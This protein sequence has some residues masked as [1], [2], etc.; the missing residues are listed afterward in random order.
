MIQNFRNILSL[1]KSSK[2]LN[3]ATLFLI[4]A[5]VPL[6][7]FIAQQQQE[8]RQRASGPITAP[9]PSPTFIFGKSVLFNNISTQNIQK[10]TI[11]RNQNNTLKLNF[12]FT[13]EFWVKFKE[14]PATEQ[15]L[16][17]V[18][19]RL[20]VI[21]RKD[22]YGYTTRVV[23]TSDGTRSDVFDSNPVLQANKWYHMA[24]TY[25]KSAYGTTS[26]VIYAD[27]N[28]TYWSNE[29]FKDDFS[30]IVI[31]EIA[32]GEIDEI[33][34]SNTARYPYTSGPSTYTKP[35]LPFA[36]D[37]NTMVLLHLD[38]NTKDTS[39]NDNDGIFSGTPAFVNSTVG[40]A[41]VSITPPTPFVCTPCS[42]DINKN[43]SV[44]TFDFT[45]V[46][47]CRNKTLSDK[48][49][50]GKSCSLADINKDG[51]INDIDYSCLQSKLGQRCIAPTPIPTLNPTSTPIPNPNPTKNPVK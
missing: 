47:D 39:G 49:R 44:D 20:K 31:G 37:S 40:P 12:D 41:L 24:F 19:N 27:G 38:D 29:P 18:G 33:R 14:L 46:N 5:A 51:N 17:S 15:T 21:T 25:L 3:L 42:A 23:T 32:N 6:T 35:S 28:S 30:N 26:Y 48:D 50:Y 13:I 4:V 9:I 2:A 7:V 10:L 43:G 11:L 8:T 34:I 16:L 45:N 36:A 1:F 22:V